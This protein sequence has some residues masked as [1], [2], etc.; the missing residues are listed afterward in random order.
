MIFLKKRERD[1]GRE[2]EG[3]K[4]KGERKKTR[5]AVCSLDAQWGKMGSGSGYQVL[6]WAELC[7]KE[8]GPE[9]HKRTEETLVRD[10]VLGEGYG[11]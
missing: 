7:S 9:G 11:R 6:V 3:R 10:P 8:K 5:K 4:R 2:E 1:R